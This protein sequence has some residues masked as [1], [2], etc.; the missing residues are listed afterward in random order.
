MVSG[1]WWLCGDDDSGIV[2]SLIS[3]EGERTLGERVNTRGVIL[4]AENLKK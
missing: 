4:T 2:L 1:G 3:R